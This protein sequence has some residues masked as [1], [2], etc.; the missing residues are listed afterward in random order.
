[1]KLLEAEMDL[2]RAT[3]E[4]LDERLSRI[5]RQLEP[6]PEPYVPSM[7]ATAAAKLLGIDRHELKRLTAA[8]E[9]PHLRMTQGGRYVYSRASIATS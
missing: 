9:V 1:M 4:E 6:A 8:G 7:T 2:L 3:V 5:E